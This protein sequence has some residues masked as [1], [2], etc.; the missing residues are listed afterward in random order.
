LAPGGTLA[1]SVEEATAGTARFELRSSSRYAHAEGYLHQL[2]R[3]QGFD[4]LASSRLVLR[5]EQRR[6]IHGLLVLLAP[7]AAA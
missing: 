3:E 6:P 5:Y 2:A 4:W 1:F 7:A